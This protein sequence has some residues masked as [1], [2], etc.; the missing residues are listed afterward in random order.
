[1]NKLTFKSNLLGRPP[2]RYSNIGMTCGTGDC[3]EAAIVKGRC[4]NHYQ[5][6]HNAQKAKTLR[7]AQRLG[8]VK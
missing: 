4:F 1:M 5:K 2:K 3:N 8:L 7:A 6:W